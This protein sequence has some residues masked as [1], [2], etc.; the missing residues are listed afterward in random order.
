[1][2]C[3]P[4]KIKSVYTSGDEALKNDTMYVSHL[5]PVMKHIKIIPSGTVKIEL[6]MT[7]INFV[8]RR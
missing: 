2:T 6:D 8:L 5:G 7:W 3:F 1:M 4:I